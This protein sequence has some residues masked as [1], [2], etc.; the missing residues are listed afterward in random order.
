VPCIVEAAAERASC[1]AAAR[2]AT[3]R[4][5]L[6]VSALSL[7]IAVLFSVRLRRFLTVLC[8]LMKMAGCGVSVVSRRLVITRFV[9]LAGFAVMSSCVLVMLRG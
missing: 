5:E 7:L 9:M 1:F 2:P 3:V 6:G 4:F 8:G